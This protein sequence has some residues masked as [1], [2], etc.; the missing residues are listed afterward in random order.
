IAAHLPYS[1]SHHVALVDG[2]TLYVIGGQTGNTND[3]SG[4]PH[5]EVQIATLAADGSVGA[6]SQGPA[7]PQAYETSAGIIHDGFVYVVGGVVDTTSNEASGVPTANVL[8]AKILGPGKLDAWALD[9]A[10]KLPFA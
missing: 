4:M 7:L 1:L 8:R 6:F 3:N 5:K 9:K 2:D 10:S